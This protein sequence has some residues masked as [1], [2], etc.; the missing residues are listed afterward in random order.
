VVFWSIAP[1]ER[2]AKTAKRGAQKVQLRAPE[3][4]LVIPT[5][6]VL[7]T[8]YDEDCSKLQTNGAGNWLG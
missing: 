7:K 6:Y 8:L 3:T 2:E 1:I 4:N 5:C